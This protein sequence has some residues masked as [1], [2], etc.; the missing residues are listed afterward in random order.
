MCFLYLLSNHIFPYQL[1]FCKWEWKESFQNGWMIELVTY[2][3]CLQSIF[4]ICIDSTIQL[5]WISILSAVAIW[6]FSFFFSS[7][8]TSN[9]IEIID[10][11]NCQQSDVSIQLHIKGEII[12]FWIQIWTLSLISNEI[13]SYR[14][15]LA[16]SVSS[17]VRQR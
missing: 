11:S 17:W 15:N 3:L 9:K 2:F 14:F 6:F 12:L 8:G 13:L 1:I 4:I 16:E 10:I 5:C 7:L